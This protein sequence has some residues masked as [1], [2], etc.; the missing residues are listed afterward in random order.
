VADEQ[1]AHPVDVQRWADLAEHVL[2]AS[3]IRGEAEL[4]MLFV[5]ETTMAGLNRRFMGQEGATDVLSFPID[6]DVVEVGRAPDASTTGPDRG[7]AQPTDVPVMLGDVVVCPAV[8]ARQ[9]TD[10]AGTYDDE[11]ALL[12]V[13]GV[14][15][16]LGMDHAEP[17][18]EVAMQ[19][20][21]RDLLER[22]HE[23]A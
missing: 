18:E 7:S 14:L 11:L 8:A 13:H 5:D 9:A 12:I 17:A 22:F 4:S 3:G 20:R 21:E 1:A 10:H 23:P 2:E 15:H 6:D 19:R 16:V